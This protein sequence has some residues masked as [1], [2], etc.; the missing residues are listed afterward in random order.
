LIIT[1]DVGGE[2]LMR[3]N[4]LMLRDTVIRA[5]VEVLIRFVRWSCL[6]IYSVKH[7]SAPVE[8]PK[9]WDATWVT[10]I[11]RLFVIWRYEMERFLDY[12][13]DTLANAGATS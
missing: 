11:I 12:V 1:Q 2:E 7:P 3:E 4:W 13:A 8:T 9:A 5:G 6:N 10:A